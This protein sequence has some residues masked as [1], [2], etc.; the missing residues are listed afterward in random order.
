M[1]PELENLLDE[2]TKK[3]DASVRARVAVPG[4]RCRHNCKG[5]SCEL[6]EGHAGLHLTITSGGFGWWDTR[7]SDEPTYWDRLIGS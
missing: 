7:H 2:R 1:S 5:T 6:P 4:A 3:W